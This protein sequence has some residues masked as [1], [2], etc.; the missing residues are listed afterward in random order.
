MLAYGVRCGFSIFLET[1][2][3][4][5]HYQLLL[6]D[7]SFQDFAT[8]CSLKQ[9]TSCII[10]YICSSITE[11][12]IC[13]GEFA[14][15]KHMSIY[16]LNP[17]FILRGIMPIQSLL[18]GTLQDRFKKEASKLCWIST[19]AAARTP[20]LDLSML[21]SRGVQPS[22][23][24]GGQWTQSTVC[25]SQSQLHHSTQCNVGILLPPPAPISP[26]IE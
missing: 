14:R 6:M 19:L 24:Y 3:F 4:L 13:R 7:R 21:F 22:R 9:L 11:G 12:Y 16:N 17:V 20:P 1:T 8:T 5:Y 18:L 10:I 2:V 15:S 25:E 23:W 26:T